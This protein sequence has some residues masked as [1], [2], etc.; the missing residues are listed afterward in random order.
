MLVFLRLL[1]LPCLLQIYEKKGRAGR[2]QML[3]NGLALWWS[4]FFW[5]WIR[6]WFEKC[7]YPFPLTPADWIGYVLLK[8]WGVANKVFHCV[9]Y[10]YIGAANYLASM[11]WCCRHKKICKI[12]IFARCLQDASVSSPIG[13]ACLL[14]IYEKKGRAGSW[15]MLAN[16]L[17]LVQ[18]CQLHH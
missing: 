5:L 8:R 6:P 3:A 18:L 4:Q 11:C 14:Q 2:W 9:I 10:H 16:G 12:W 13:A 1:V 15:K 17:A 7:S